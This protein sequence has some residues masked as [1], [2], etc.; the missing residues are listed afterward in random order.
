MYY[1]RKEVR[2]WQDPQGER[3]IKL[4]NRFKANLVSINE[5]GVYGLNFLFVEI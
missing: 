2:R 4:N 1:V 3:V 5:K